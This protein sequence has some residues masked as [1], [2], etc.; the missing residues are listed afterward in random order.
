[1]LRYARLSVLVSVLLS[2][3]VWA[4]GVH[5]LVPDRFRVAGGDAVNLRVES[6]RGEKTETVDWPAQRIGWFF[7]RNG[8]TQENQDTVLPRDPQERAIAYRIDHAGGAV[9]G[10]D[11]KPRLETWTAAELDAFVSEC[12]SGSPTTP[13]PPKAANTDWRVRRIETLRTLVRASPAGVEESEASSTAILA[14]TGQ[15]VEI[16]LMADPTIATIGSDV[17][18]KT[19]VRGDKCAGAAG[20]AICLSDGS[21]QTFTTDPTGAAHFKLTR[22]GVWLVEFR[23]VEP[24]PPG[25]D[26]DWLIHS[27]T[28]TF[29]V[30]S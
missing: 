20:R 12:R 22:G 5:T 10:M 13:A 3:T 24:A 26:H 16:R 19:Y 17:P 11:L 2:G 18:L 27:A 6:R 28:L 9:I 4:Q 14:K 25:S 1:M 15:A 7:V 30:R 8:G 23:H 21:R 29:E